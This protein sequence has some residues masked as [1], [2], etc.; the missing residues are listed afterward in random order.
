MAKKVKCSQCK[1]HKPRPIFISGD[2]PF[3][4]EEFICEADT[5]LLFVES[6]IS[7][8]REC[9]LFKSRTE[10]AR[11]EVKKDIIRAIPNFI[12]GIIGIF[13]K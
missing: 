7:Q 11:E 10:T 1:Y 3:E 13:K 8:I 4:E 12:K 6:E 5:S 2:S 9:H